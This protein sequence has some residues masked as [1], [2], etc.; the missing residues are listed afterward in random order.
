[1]AGGRSTRMRT[2]AALLS[3]ALLIAAVAAPPS[4]P[5]SSSA[6]QANPAEATDAQERDEERARPTRAAADREDEREPRANRR[7]RAEAD[8]D[9]EAPAPDSNGAAD[10]DAAARKLMLTASQEQAVGIRIDTPLPLTSSPAIDAYATVLDP[11]ALLSDAGHL[12]STR[13]LAAAASADA[14]RQESLYRDSTQAS[15]KAVQASRAQAVEANAQAQAAL[16]SFKLQWGPLAALS[17]VQRDALLGNS[18]AAAICCCAPTSPDV[19]SAARWDLR[20]CWR[21]MA[22]RSPPT[23]SGRCRAPMR[24]RKAPAGCWRSIARRRASVPARAPR[25]ASPRPRRAA[26]WC[27]RLTHLRGTGDLRLPA[28]ARSSADRLRSKPCRSNRFARGTGIAHRR[29]DGR[30][31]RSAGAGVLCH[32]RALRASQPPKRSTTSAMLAAI[33][34]VAGASQGRH[35]TLPCSSLCFEPRRCSTRGS[36][37]PDFAPPHVLRPGRGAGPGRDA[38]GI[39]RHPSA[40]GSAGRRRERRSGAFRVPAGLSAIQVVFGRDSDPYLR[41]QVITE[42][43]TDSARCCR[44]GE[45]AAAVAAQFLDGVPAALSLR[46]VGSSPL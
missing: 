16:L 14:A 11:V 23:C 41:R 37:I 26:C 1:M 10:E 39:P 15:L 35:G 44:G 46:G 36:T 19:I 20:R 28:G 22:R 27:R 33:V 9:H 21:W 32:S 12:E 25:R 42:R 2:L 40:R 45:P 17:P 34:R 30:P 43:L 13:A 18:A 31:D 4:P 38:G 7:Q 6:P 3:W 5:G 8:A 29:L 24:R